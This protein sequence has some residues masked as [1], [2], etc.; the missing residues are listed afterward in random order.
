MSCF[1]VPHCELR[2][3]IRSFELEVQF[4]GGIFNFFFHLFG[5]VSGVFLACLASGPVPCIRMAPEFRRSPARPP[6]FYYAHGGQMSVGCGILQ[7]TFLEKVL[8]CFSNHVIAQT[9]SRKWYMFK[10]VSICL[11]QKRRKCSLIYAHHFEVF[12]FAFSPGMN[13]PGV[14]FSRPQI[15]FRL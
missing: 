1:K 7:R 4:G 13:C 15:W 5:L 9:T 10:M 14:L 6:R 8:R 11:F 3:W 12:F 2:M